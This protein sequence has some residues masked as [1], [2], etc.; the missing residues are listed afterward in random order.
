M[1]HAA[2]TKR[3][4]TM[5]SN[6]ARTHSIPKAYIFRHRDGSCAAFIGSSNLSEMAL[7]SG[8]EWNYRALDSKDPSGLREAFD[9]FDRLF[10]DPRTVELTPEWIEAYRNRRSVLKA[11]QVQL[12][13]PDEPPPV[14]PNPHKIQ[15]EALELLQET[16][17]EGHIAGLVVLATGLGKTWLSAF[18]SAA[19]KRVLFVAHREEILTQALE[20]FRLIRPH[21]VLGRYTGEEKAA[22]ASVLF[23][24]IQTLSRQGTSR[25]LSKRTNL[26]T[27]SWTS[28]IMRR[29]TPIGA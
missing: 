26:I 6:Y 11:T 22:S 16:R 9:A 10:N 19:F 24:S 29:L 8:V 5:R 23:A 1:S 28:F 13:V 3:I 4:G 15:T 7:K 18:D 25:S 2:C 21:D 27:S 20:T 14:I 17:A 12:E